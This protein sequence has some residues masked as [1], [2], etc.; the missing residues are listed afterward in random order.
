M[1]SAVA[2][3][4]KFKLAP[5]PEPVPFVPFVPFVG[6]A[7]SALGR[8]GVSGDSSRA[9]SLPVEAARLLE[10]ACGDKRPWLLDAR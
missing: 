8:P 6:A 2:P 1:S 4:K 9:S 5:V 3:F 10:E 7:D